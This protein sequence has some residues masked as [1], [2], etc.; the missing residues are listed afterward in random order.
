MAEGLVAVIVGAIIS[1][2]GAVVASAV[3]P[4]P[5]TPPEPEAPPLG[6]AEERADV[7][8]R[9]R[10][11]RLRARGQPST[12]LA[13][14]PLGQPGPGASRGATLTGGGGYPT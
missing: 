9:E 10:Q 3:A 13:G 4:E 12:I 8:S 5:E 11:K 1:A 7:A 6:L 2:T 14:S